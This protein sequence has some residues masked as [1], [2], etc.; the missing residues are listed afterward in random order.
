MIL[1]E[2]RHT[3]GSAATLDDLFRR[4]GVRHPDSIALVDPPNREEFTDSTP[5]T[6]TFA[7]ADRA[8]SAL[9]ARL[10]ELGLQTDS[11]VAMQLPNTVESLISFLAILRAGMIAMPIPLLS[12]QQE[13]VAALGRVGAKAIVTTARIGSL[14]HADIAMRA[15]VELF[16]IRHVCAFGNNLPDGVT[17]LDG[18]FTSDDGDLTPAFPRPG[19]AAAHVAA[20]TFDLDASGPVPI[21]RSHVELVAG[22]LE[23]FL[24]T[25]GSPDRPLLSTI[26]VSSFAGIALTALPWL[27][28]GGTL[29]LHH[30]FNPEA[31][32]AQVWEVANGAVTLPAATV[33]PIADA[34]L[35]GDNIQTVVALW[36]SPERLSAAKVWQGS[37]TV[38]D[39]ACF[40]ETGLV[41]ARRGANGLPVQIPYGAV[42]VTRRPTGAPTVIQATRTAGGTLAL[43]GRMVSTHALGERSPHSRLTSDQA[44]YVDTGFACQVERNGQALA[45]T[46]SPPGFTAIGGYRFLQSDIDELVAQADPTATIVALPDVDLG[47][48]LAGSAEH[49]DALCAKLQARGT[50]PLITGAFR[51]R[52]GI[53]AA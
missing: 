31:F 46:T 37:A 21:A 27:L 42:D 1:G 51:P 53:K 22:G 12:R 38:I 36:R 44:G 2:S 9:A 7:E 43:R 16:Q 24:E 17:P 47:L 26:P 25:D 6:L 11:L 5:R 34:G 15:A 8:I 32:A 14:S 18:V 3:A 35:L 45:V 39:V 40:G 52:R 19:V 50:N 28:T 48:R 33:V 41:A 29:H 4:A 20:V 23:T 10:R 30:C 13:I 49:R